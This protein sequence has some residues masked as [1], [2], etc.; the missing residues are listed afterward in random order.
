[1]LIVS[2]IGLTTMLLLFSMLGHMGRW[3]S[4]AEAA[5]ERSGAM[6]HAAGTITDLLFMAGYRCSV[7]GIHDMGPD[8]LTV[9]YLV[10]GADEVPGSI[11]RHRLFTVRRD[12]DKLKLT[13]RRRRLPLDVEPA[14]EDGST[15][16][17]ADDLA[18]LSFRYL[19]GRG[20]ETAVPGRVR[21]VEFSFR[22]GSVPGD[23][24]SRYRSAVRLRNVRG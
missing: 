17:L 24:G 18:D 14:W 11:S 23:S 15:S 3:W 20:E 9:E 5:G 22:L 4:G 12:G 16:I 21:L 6:R 13:T 8:H 10:E 2:T 19:D 7:A 1:M